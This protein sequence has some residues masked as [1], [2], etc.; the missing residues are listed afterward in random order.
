MLKRLGIAGD[1]ASRLRAYPHGAAAMQ[2]LARARDRTSLGC[3]QVT[4][5]KYT[6]GVTL[7]GTL[8]PPFELSTLYSVAIATDAHD[9]A[10]SRA[11]AALVAGPATRQLRIDGGFDVA[12]DDATR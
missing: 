7:V 5:I 3:T 1:M 8:P 2:A 9:A 11:F 12:R 6:S 10:R 4:E